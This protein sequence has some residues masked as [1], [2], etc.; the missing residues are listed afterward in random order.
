MREGILMF[1]VAQAVSGRLDG[2][3]NDRGRCNKGGVV[4]FKAGSFCMMNIISGA[5][6]QA[7]GDFGSLQS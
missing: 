4:I 7:Y 6:I 5:Q 3:G 2:F 1:I